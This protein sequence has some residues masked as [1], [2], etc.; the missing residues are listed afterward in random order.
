LFES[1]SSSPA[2]GPAEEFDAGRVEK[3]K[4]SL[5]E[6]L[7]N[8]THIRALKPDDFI[9]LVV[10]GADIARAEVKRFR[11]DG[12][13]KADSNRAGYTVVRKG[14]GGGQSVMTI[15]LK[16]ADADACAQGKLTPDDFRKK[17]AIQTYLRKSDASSAANYF[18]QTVR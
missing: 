17:A 11:A 6:A 8:A 2:R 13:N 12:N 5:L 9:T 14:G 10:Q 15:R 7:R 18:L 3:L 1:W 4:E 16:K